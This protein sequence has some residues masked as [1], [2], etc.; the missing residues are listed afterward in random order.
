M[1][2]SLLAN[3][4]AA[5]FHFLRA[6]V[7]GG[8]AEATPEAGVGISALSDILAGWITFGDPAVD[9]HVVR[10][11]RVQSSYHGPILGVVPPTFRGLVPLYD[12]PFA[13]PWVQA[14][15]GGD[16]STFKA[17]EA[18]IAGH[19]LFNVPGLWEL[20]PRRGYLG[21]SLGIGAEGTV[22]DGAPASG[23]AKAEAGFLAGIT[24]RDTWYIQA[25]TVGSVSLFGE[26]YTN[27]NTAAVTGVFLDRVGLPV[28]LEVRGELDHG[29]DT[30][31]R[32]VETTWAVR[33]AL[34]WK[35][36][37]PFQTRIEEQLER[38]REQAGRTP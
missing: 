11:W 2:L 18:D 24:L 4:D 28:G 3:A 31:S 7:I 13:I 27:L 15:L 14:H 25:R 12:V 17:F 36:V 9:G 38:R 16:A 20:D 29:G 23:Q 21:P 6:E 30:R 26:H 10:A 33:A 8:A 37:P 19:Y 1:L 22:W 5:G 34:F 35:L 32:A